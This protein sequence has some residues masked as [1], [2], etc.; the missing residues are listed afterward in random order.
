MYRKISKDQDMEEF[1]AD[2]LSRPMI[3]TA[4]KGH[5]TAEAKKRIVKKILRPMVASRKSCEVEQEEET[6]QGD[7]IED[8]CGP[9]AQGIENPK[10]GLRDG[11]RSTRILLEPRPAARASDPSGSTT[12]TDTVTRGPNDANRT[13]GAEEQGEA[14]GDAGCYP[15]EYGNP[16][17]VVG[18]QVPD[19]PPT[20]PNPPLRPL[21]PMPYG[22]VAGME[23]KPEGAPG[24]F[25]GRG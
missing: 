25:R 21:R 14:T 3:P 11:E 24:L 18:G 23:S 1:Y 20:P 17:K 8:Q 15:L 4:P 13:N 22:P 10:Y 19:F 6:Q 12:T 7:P 9:D 2:V 16:Q 5:V